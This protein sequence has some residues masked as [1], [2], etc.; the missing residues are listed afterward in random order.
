MGQLEPNAT[1]I[2]ERADGITY[3]RKIGEQ[4]RFIVGYD[5]SVKESK[6]KEQEMLIWAD[7]LEAAKTNKSL[8]KALE[9]VKVLYRLSKDSPL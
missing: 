4:D 3:A 8:Q 2:Y 9:R 1:Y 5:Y 6:E 7:I